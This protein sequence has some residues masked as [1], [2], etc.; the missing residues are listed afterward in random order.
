MPDFDF[1]LGVLLGV[2][3]LLKLFD[4]Q[5]EDGVS[6]KEF[7]VN[8]LFYG[9]SLVS[10]AVVGVLVQ[11]FVSDRLARREMEHGIQRFSDSVIHWV[12]LTFPCYQCN[13]SSI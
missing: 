7:D 10:L 3:Q 1:F 9:E 6:V 11:G 12:I 2:E 4:S 5:V 8:L 13:G